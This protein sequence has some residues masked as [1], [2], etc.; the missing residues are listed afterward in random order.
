M[1]LLGRGLEIQ[2]EDVFENRLVILT[3]TCSLYM[4]SLMAENALIFP[5]LTFLIQN[6]IY[7]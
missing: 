2:F 7:I 6:Q 4:D 1:F 3:L 5:F